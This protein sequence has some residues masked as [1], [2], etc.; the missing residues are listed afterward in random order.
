MLQNVIG[1][2]SEKVRNT[3]ERGM[4]KR[5]AEAIGDPHPVF[6]DEEAGRDSRYGRNIAPPTFPR[7]FDYGKIEGLGLPDKGLI[8]GEQT[9]HYTRPL[10]VGEDVFCW[11][12]VESYKEKQGSNGRMGILTICRYGESLDGTGIFVEKQV[13]ILTEAVMKGMGI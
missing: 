13:I 7:V 2:T 5:F 4:V 3:V 9:Y 1:K 11:S 8:H 10:L 6:V 12:E